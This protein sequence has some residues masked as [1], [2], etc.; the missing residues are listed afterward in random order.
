MTDQKHE[1]LITIVIP[2]CLFDLMCDTW[3]ITGHYKVE[4]FDSN[5]NNYV[6]SVPGWGMHVEIQ[7]TDDKVILS[8]VSSDCVFVSGYSSELIVPLFWLKIDI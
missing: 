3:W 4:V 6:P 1:C 7:D 5:T 8:R 2:I